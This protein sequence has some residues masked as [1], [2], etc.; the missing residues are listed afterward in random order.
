MVIIIGFPLLMII[1]FW[2]FI[3]I[4]QFSGFFENHPIVEWVFLLFAV[5]YAFT[6]LIVIV[7]IGLS[8]FKKW[9]N[10]KDDN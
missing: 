7:K 3:I 10:K 6:L 4:A 5:S 1:V 2:P 8:D 9:F